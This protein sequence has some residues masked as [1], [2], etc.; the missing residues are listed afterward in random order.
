LH[1]VSTTINEWLLYRKRHL[2][3]ITPLLYSWV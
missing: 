1:V 3:N 2:E